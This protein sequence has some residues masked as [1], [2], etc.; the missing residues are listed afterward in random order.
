MQP[1]EFI[2][3]RKVEQHLKDENWMLHYLCRRR[4]KKS[5]YVC[6]EKRALNCLARAEVEHSTNLIVQQLGIHIHDS[7]LLHRKMRD[8][9]NQAIKI[10]VKNNAVP[11]SV[12]GNLD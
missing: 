6:L 5:Y 11:S 3:A 2:P 7:N 12:L 1:A 9:K 4:K 10:A 8:L